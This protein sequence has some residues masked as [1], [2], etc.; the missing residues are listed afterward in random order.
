MFNEIIHSKINCV[1]CVFAVSV[2]TCEAIA[3]VRRKL[4]RI[5]SN[6]ILYL[7]E[8]YR[9]EGDVNNYTIVLP[10]E[11]SNIETTSTS[12][13]ALRYDM[14]ACTSGKTTLPP[15][16][17]DSS[18]RD[19]GITTQMLLNYIR[20]L[21]AQAAGALDIYPLILVVD[22]ASIHDTEK[23]M[24]TFHEWGCQSLVEIVKLPTATAKRISPLDNALFN[25]WKQKVL[26]KG[27]LTK[28]NI[29]TRMSDAWNEITS[30]QIHQQ[31]K[32]SGLMR[33]TNLYFDCPNPTVH[34]HNK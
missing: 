29:R 9:R 6:H 8:T 4:Q 22:R 21:L 17:Y 23:M 5:G 26:E 24:E 31:Y 1:F 33:H 15:I 14:I 20:N 12:R 18:E 19:S 11:P 16:I 30:K 34:R 25:I 32:K 10:Q 2:E 27:P 3:K 7:D 13:Y 28:T